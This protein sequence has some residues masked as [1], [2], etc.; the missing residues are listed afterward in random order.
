MSKHI[1]KPESGKKR[2]AKSRPQ[3]MTVD[4]IRPEI[5]KVLHNRLPR[6]YWAPS[7]VQTAIAALAKSRLERFRGS[8]KTR[9]RGRE[10]ETRSGPY[11]ASRIRH[12]VTRQ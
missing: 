8:T 12:E 10:S 2:E 3:R 5:T 7:S 11:L 1:R 4:E 6:K 9:G